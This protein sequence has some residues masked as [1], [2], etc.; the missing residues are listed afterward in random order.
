MFHSIDPSQIYADAGRRLEG[1]VAVVTG[2]SSG[3]GRAISLALAA[4]GAK[5]VCV[6]LQKSASPH[7]FEPDKDIDTD[8]V[9]RNRGGSA[10]FIA[11]NVSHSEDLDAAAALAVKKFGSLDIWVNNAGMF[12]GVASVLDES[13][14]QFRKTLE[15]NAIG[16]WLG[17]KAAVR[18]MREQPLRGRSRGKIVN[19]GSVAGTIGQAN[20]GSYSTSKG[21]V[22]NLTRALAIECAPDAI[23]VNAIAPG[24]FPTAM[25]RGYFD[26]PEGLE[27]VKKIH[28]WPE[29]GE[30][31]DV[32]AATAF[33][34]SIGADWITG[35]VLPVDGGFVAQ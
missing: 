30:P 29:L 35:V 31:A 17:C 1:R 10:V 28:P 8:D 18:V 27:A 4:E 2:S 13:P 16:T 24:Y 19:I 21:G 14:E 15:V 3:H 11:G 22:H 20:S 9:I 5:L 33:L 6:D 25:A 32:A 7:G 34:S 26:S 12:A 23:N